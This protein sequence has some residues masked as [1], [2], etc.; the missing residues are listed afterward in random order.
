MRTERLLSIWIFSLLGLAFNRASNPSVED[1]PKYTKLMG[2]VA[3][4]YSVTKLQPNSLF[5]EE[6]NHMDFYAN[7]YKNIKPKRL[8][9]K[10]N[11]LLVIGKTMLCE[12]E[13]L[14]LDCLAYLR[15]IKAHAPIINDI[16]QA[17]EY[18]I[19]SSVQTDLKAYNKIMDRMEE[20]LNVFQDRASIVS[21]KSL[22]NDYI[23][24]YRATASGANKDIQC[25][26]IMHI[27]DLLKTTNNMMVNMGE[28]NI[29]LYSAIVNI[30]RFLNKIPQN[31]NCFIGNPKY[32]MNHSCWIC[33]LHNRAFYDIPTVAFYIEQFPNSNTHQHLTRELKSV[34][35]I[36]HIQEVLAILCIEGMKRKIG[37]PVQKYMQASVDMYPGEKMYIYF[38][39]QDFYKAE[40]N[41]ILENAISD[42][43]VSKNAT[44]SMESSGTDVPAESTALAFLKDC[45]RCIGNYRVFPADQLAKKYASLPLSRLHD[46]AIENCIFEKI[47]YKLCGRI[48][49]LFK[50]GTVPI[51]YEESMLL[52]EE[53]KG[54][55]KRAAEIL[56]HSY[57]ILDESTKREL[58]LA[59]NQ[60][61]VYTSSINYIFDICLSILTNYMKIMKFNN[62]ACGDPE[63]QLLSF[64]E[65]EKDRFTFMVNSMIIQFLALEDTVQKEY[66]KLLA[67]VDKVDL[68]TS[69]NLQK[70]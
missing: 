27:L 59:F 39:H 45:R 40:T 6:R 19:A 11:E 46:I 48:K 64:G 65:K 52:Q 38:L 47:T 53:V 54:T 9:S 66:P 43:S 33:R 67:I 23:M 37:P 5:A 56:K 22:L 51:Y 60:T 50:M 4:F 42:S 35:Y 13:Y 57:A 1:D 17:K 10:I 70:R 41:K 26:L 3:K 14:Y 21:L 24:I 61:C 28:V 55:I 30:T 44:K 69:S 36:E 32:C 12:I 49:S 31:G 29:H 2:R 7:I 34:M 62:G 20:T 15:I 58:C 68:Q 63:N 16:F 8:K 18:A 25:D